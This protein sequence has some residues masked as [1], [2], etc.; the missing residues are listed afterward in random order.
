MNKRIKGHNNLLVGLG[1][2]GEKIGQK[3][4]ICDDKI[5]KRKGEKKKDWLGTLKVVKA[6]Q[7]VSHSNFIARLLQSS[8]MKV[9]LHQYLIE[10]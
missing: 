10:K 7:H 6:S 9:H 4:K 3:K 1:C 2:G 5:L 8:S